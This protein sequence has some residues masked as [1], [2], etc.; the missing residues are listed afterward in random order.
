MLCPSQ[1][2]EPF[3]LVAIEAM[4]TGTPVIAADNGGFCETVYHGQTGFRCLTLGDWLSAVDCLANR[5]Q[6]PIDLE[7][8]TALLADYAKDYYGMPRV[9]HLLDCIF[10]QVKSLDGKGWYECEPFNA[11]LAQSIYFG[12]I[13]LH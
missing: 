7:R 6:Q 12:S 11:V 9:G 5:K 1:Y 2:C 10:R 3:G 4:A 13:Y 8:Q